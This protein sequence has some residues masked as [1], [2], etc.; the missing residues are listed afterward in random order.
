M[1]ICAMLLLD[2]ISSAEI[3]PKTPVQVAIY[4]PNTV[5]GVPIPVIIQETERQNKLIRQR[6][7]ENNIRQQNEAKKSRD[8]LA[9]YN[10]RISHNPTNADT[11]NS[12]ANLKFTS[13]DDYQGALADYN[14]AISLD[15]KFVVAY[16]N[17]GTLKHVRQD[18]QGALADYN[19][20]ISL[21]PRFA[22]AYYNRGLLKNK[23]MKN[24]PEALQDLRQAQQLFKAQGDQQSFQA[25]SNSMLKLG[26]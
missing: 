10:S 8:V 11:Y 20:A 21:N 18:I 25:V 5:G 13:F 6:N 17:R 9:Y 24:R 14:Q 26:G 7:E 23:F 3:A 19:Q 2:A 4:Q 1:L 12:R 22:D 16:F 15:P